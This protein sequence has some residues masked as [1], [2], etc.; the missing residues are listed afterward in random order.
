MPQWR[1]NFIFHLRNGNV[2]K[3]PRLFAANFTKN[4][5]SEMFDLS[6]RFI[7]VGIPINRESVVSRAQKINCQSG[8]LPPFPS[9]QNYSIPSSEIIFANALIISFE[10]KVCTCQFS[11]AASFAC[12]GP[13]LFVCECGRSLLLRRARAGE[14]DTLNI[15][16]RIRAQSSA[17]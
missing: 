5:P 8:K 13:F 1:E 7:S 16:R 11:V 4:A 2:S 15:F 17:S 12:S 9:G 3:L 6:I 10:R 14:G